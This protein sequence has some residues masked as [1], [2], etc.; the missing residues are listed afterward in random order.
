MAVYYKHQSLYKQREYCILC[1]QFNSHVTQYCQQWNNY[2]NHEEALLRT[3]LR[4]KKTEKY[5]DTIYKMVWS[6]KGLSL[7]HEWQKKT[8]VNSCVSPT[9]QENGLWRI[10]RTANEV[11]WNT[12]VL[13]RNYSNAH[14]RGYKKLQRE[15]TVWVMIKA[16]ELINSY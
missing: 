11:G 6:W 3:K 13:P 4:T 10:L 1:Y 2:T 15:S 14:K 16:S 7:I 8:N 12:V 5:V 9:A